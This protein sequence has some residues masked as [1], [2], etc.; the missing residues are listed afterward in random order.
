LTFE[1]PRFPVVPN[2]SA[3]PATHPSALRDLLSRHLV[4][5]VR[6]ERSMRAMADEGIELF[7]EAGPGEVLAKLAKRCVPGVRAVA[8]GTPEAAKSLV[9]EIGVIVT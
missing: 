2:A 5:P 7:V 1:F 9:A 3:R 8:V 6:W 4:S